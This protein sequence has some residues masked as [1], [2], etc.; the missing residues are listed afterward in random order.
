MRLCEQLMPIGSQ[1]H[2]HFIQCV[3]FHHVNIVNV[4]FMK[5]RGFQAVENKTKT[6]FLEF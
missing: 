4:M 5:Q 2:S 3:I 1:L 6:H